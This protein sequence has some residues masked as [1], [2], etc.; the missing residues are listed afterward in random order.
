[1]TPEAY[2][3]ASIAQRFWESKN[4]LPIYN[5]FHFA[6]RLAFVLNDTKAKK[7]LADFYRSEL[8]NVTK[9]EQ[10][11][12]VNEVLKNPSNPT[13]TKRVE[14][15]KSYPT[16]RSSARYCFATLFSKK[17][18]DIDFTPFTIDSIALEDVKS[19]QAKLLEDRKAIL[20]LSTYALNF[21][22]LT[23][24]FQK[25]FNEEE[26]IKNLYKI[27]DDAW[28]L[29]EMTLQKRIYFITHM[30]INDS[31]FYTRSIPHSHKQIHSLYTAKLEL[32]IKND[33]KKVSFDCLSEFV[34]ANH[35]LDLHSKIDNDIFSL[36]VNA[37]HSEKPFIVEPQNPSMTITQAEHLNA[38]FIL[39]FY[40]RIST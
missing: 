1:M 9:A 13:E 25:T 32:E 3:P 17:I 8:E 21:L 4:E 24:H 5:W 35:L 19:V 39:A 18:W 27:L 22:I 20:I 28:E 2:S 26:L 10:W 12:T 11:N 37:T 38:L 6:T 36:I 40:N 29:P 30:I 23:N 34:A 16:L 31:L 14:L 15:L 7:E 33:I